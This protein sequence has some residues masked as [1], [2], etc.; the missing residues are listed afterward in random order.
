MTLYS[1]Q[2]IQEQNPCHIQFTNRMR[3]V[4]YNPIWIEEFDHKLLKAYAE[5]KGITLKE[6]IHQYSKKLKQ[7]DIIPKSTK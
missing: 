1:T 2:S 4:K 5:K 3:T 6:L 7:R